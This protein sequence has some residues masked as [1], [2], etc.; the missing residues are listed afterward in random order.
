MMFQVKQL[1]FIIEKQ[2]FDN[3]QNW[4]NFIKNFK[5]EDSIVILAGN[6]SDL[7]K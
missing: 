7:E 5:T 1:I 3:V 6:K 2:S 4:I